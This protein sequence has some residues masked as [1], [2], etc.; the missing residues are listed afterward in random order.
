MGVGADSERDAIVEWLRGLHWTHM[1]KE[2][3]TRL[4]HVFERG[5]HIETVRIVA[6]PAPPH[7]PYE[8]TTTYKPPEPTTSATP[9]PAPDA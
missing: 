8:M 4:S 1:D 3:A 9:S 7:D 5:D 6:R 2:A